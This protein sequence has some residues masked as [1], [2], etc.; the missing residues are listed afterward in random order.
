MAIWNG[1]FAEP[2]GATPTDKR[3]AD[4]HASAHQWRPHAAT[5]ATHGAHLVLRPRHTANV[6]VTFP[7][8]AHVTNDKRGGRRRMY[9]T[10]RQRDC[11]S[12]KVGNGSLNGKSWRATK[13]GLGWPAQSEPAP[14]APLPCVLFGRSRSGSRL[15]YLASTTADTVGLLL[16][17]CWN[18]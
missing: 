7:Q 5:A 14:L 12:C 6:A 18:E 17:Y 13:N 8:A 1:N 11:V 3:A 15:Q 9:R 16:D 10:P 4:D 2:R